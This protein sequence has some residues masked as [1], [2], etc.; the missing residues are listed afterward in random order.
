MIVLVK[1][2]NQIGR[3]LFGVLP[4]FLETDSIVILS[5]KIKNFIKLDII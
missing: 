3:T 5:L 4:W 1:D 2:M